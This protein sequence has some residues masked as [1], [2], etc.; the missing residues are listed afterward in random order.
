MEDVESTNSADQPTIETVQQSVLPPTNEAPTTNADQMTRDLFEDDIDDDDDEE[1]YTKQSL[2]ILQMSQM[3]VHTADDAQLT[4]S[5]KQIGSVIHLKVFVRNMYDLYM[6]YQAKPFK[7]DIDNLKINVNNLQMTVSKQS[8]SGGSMMSPKRRKNDDGEFTTIDDTGIVIN[9]G[10]SSSSNNNSSHTKESETEMNVELANDEV[11][12]PDAIILKSTQLYLKIFNCLILAL[13]QMGLNLAFSREALRFFLATHRLYVHIID[14]KDTNRKEPPTDRKKRSSNGSTIRG[15]AAI[16]GA[17]LQEYMKS[18]GNF[19]SQI[20]RFHVSDVDAL[21]FVVEKNIAFPSNIYRPALMFIGD[22]YKTLSHDTLQPNYHKVSTV[23]NKLYIVCFSTNMMLLWDGNQFTL[24]SLQFERDVSFA[25]LSDACS[26][27]NDLWIVQCMIPN[28][29]IKHQSDI[30]I[31][32]VLHSKMQ[33]TLLPLPYHDRLSK[34]QSIFKRFSVPTIEPDTY[35]DS[36][37]QIPTTLN[38]TKNTRY[39]YVK[40]GY[41]LAVVGYCKNE[42]I[43]AFQRNDGHLECKIRIP[44]IGPI[45]LTV[46]SIKRVMLEKTTVQDQSEITIQ[47][48]NKTQTFKVYQLPFEVTSPTFLFERFVTIELTENHKVNHYTCG[49]LSNVSEYKPVALK[50]TIV[51]QKKSVFDELKTSIASFTAAQREEFIR[52]LQHDPV[53]DIKV[54]S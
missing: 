35:S 34:L 16:N 17:I 33:S 37:V 23:N 8:N 15:G 32:D 26:N 28:T 54:L 40:P 45:C 10:S 52:L 30:K 3:S 49:T 48:F 47:N 2:R 9:G 51:K 13:D 31:V 11:D 27:A 38:S 18:T 39:T 46:A 20:A 19:K 7:L 1:E 36:H 50:E 41:I 14:F 5:T 21:R 53:L 12:E 44:M 42:F 24:P 43:L 25:G 22:D 4:T 6:K 29:K